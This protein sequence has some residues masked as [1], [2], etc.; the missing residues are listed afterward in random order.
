MGEFKFVQCDHYNTETLRISVVCDRSVIHCETIVNNN[1]SI[2]L[3]VAEIR[4]NYKR[5]G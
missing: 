4:K 5:T 3:R 1:G 2:L